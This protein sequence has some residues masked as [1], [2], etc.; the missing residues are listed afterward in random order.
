MAFRIP[1][2]GF[3]VSFEADITDPAVGENVQFTDLSQGATDW[4]WQFGDGDTSFVQNPTHTYLAD[5][6][7]S[8]SLVAWVNDR[9]AGVSAINNY[10]TAATAFDPDATTFILAA[11]LTDPTQQ[12]AIN[13]LVVDLKDASLWTK[14]LAF[15]PL[16]GGNSTAHQYNL[17][18]TSLYNLTFSGTVTH[19]STGIR[20]TTGGYADT[21]WA[22]TT[23]PII[24][25]KGSFGFYLQNDFVINS[26]DSPMG[27]TSGANSRMCTFTV[28]AGTTFNDWGDS[29]AEMRVN[30]GALSPGN[31]V[32][33]NIAAGDNITVKYAKNGSFVASTAGTISANRNVP[34]GDD[35]FILKRTDCCPFNGTVSSAF[36]GYEISDAEST[37]L[38]TIIN[39]YQTAISRNTY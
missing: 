26:F 30:S 21:N 24:Y 8:V 20:S 38:A 17:K 10:I 39:D 27:I 6:T 25:Q 28:G 31:Y 4:Y 13:S 7:Y 35:M 22:P 12:S 34:P 5:G 14:L 15:Y 11:G 32:N 9:I 23:T 29:G 37:T 1:N 19:S 33:Y 18:D 36:I 2:N 3:K 16:V